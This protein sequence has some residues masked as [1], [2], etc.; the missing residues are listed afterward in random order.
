VIPLY[1]E[2]GPA[3]PLVWFSA[4]LRGGAALDPPGV[5]GLTRFVAELARRGAGGLDREALDA[6]IDG[7]GAHLAVEIDRDVVRLSGMALARNLDALLELAAAVLGAPAMD[8]AEHDQLVRETRHQLDELRDDDGTLADRYF[9][10][11]C[12]P[13]H[14]YGRSTLGS[15][16]T[17]ARFDRDVARGQRDRIWRRDRL[18]VGFAG[19]IDEARARAGAER[20]AAGL[21]PT[22]SPP[23]PPLVA[24]ASPPGRRIV[25][26]DKP[27]RT[28]CQMLIGHGAPPY[29]G[30]DHLALA[31][32][33]AAF[34]GMFTSRLMQEIRVRRGWSYGAGCR[35]FKARIG[36]W[37]RIDLAPSAE[38]AADALAL[39]LDLY[40][41]LG[42]DGITGDELAFARDYLLG[43]HALDR[44]TPHQRMRRRLRDALLD[45]PPDHDARLPERLA[46][47][48]LEDVRAAADRWL[49]PDA[50]CAVVVATASELVPALEKLG[51]VVDEVVPFDAY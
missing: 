7:L 36:H 23:D 19:A 48:R 26:V 50:L 37:F 11:R 22:P 32:L 40:G 47:L 6:A 28:Q 51:L 9:N 5:E 29:G 8:P 14:P 24:V 45:L 25:V 21:D 3:I 46:A 17:L 16:A 12:A 18:R 30:D 1:V 31:P 39:V 33:E 15:E 13:G 38:V 20:L 43:T 2:P 27:A 10:L 44:Q 42:R 34:G 35:I 41:A 4:A 49:T